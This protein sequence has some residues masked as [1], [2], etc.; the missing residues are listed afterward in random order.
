MNDDELLAALGAA[1]DADDPVPSHL[2]AYAT[3][4]FDLEGLDAELAELVHDSLV[5]AAPLGMRSIDTE[6][7]PRVLVYAGQD[8]SLELE[9]DGIVVHGQFAG[10]TVSRLALHTPAGTH[11]VPVAPD[12][13]FRVDL[14]T[15]SAG[16]GALRFRWT[17]SGRDMITPWSML[18]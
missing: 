14:D 10:A 3:A 7:S 6:A 16:G 4:L 5:D 11:P 2:T 18:R 8:V 17:S 15:I 9:V 1:I 13:S 12:G